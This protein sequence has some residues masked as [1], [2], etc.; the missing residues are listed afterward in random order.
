LDAEIISVEDEW[1]SQ[2]TI[3]VKDADE[4]PVSGATVKGMFDDGRA[5]TCLTDSSG[6]CQ[7]TSYKVSDTNQEAMAFTVNEVS[8]PEILLWQYDASANTDAGDDSN[9]TSMVIDR[10]VATIIAVADIDAHIEWDPIY[11]RTSAT[12]I[13]QD[14]NGLPVENAEV[15]GNW[16]QTGDSFCTTDVNGQCVFYSDNYSASKK[17]ADFE[18]KDITH[19]A[20]F[21]WEYVKDAN[22]D[23]DGDS[24]GTK[25]RAYR[26]DP[27]KMNLVDIDSETLS[28]S[29]E[30]WTQVTFTMRDEQ[31]NPM[32]ERGELFGTWSYDPSRVV[33]CD[34]DANGQ[35][36]LLS[37]KFAEGEVDVISFTVTMVEHPKPMIW[38]Y[39]A[40]Q[41]TDADGDSDGTTITIAEPTPVA[42]FVADLDAQGIQVS[43]SEWKAEVTLTVLD[44]NQ[45][46]V[47]DADVFFLWNNEDDDACT[48]DENGQCTV[49]SDK[50][51]FTQV[52]T[53]SFTITNVEHEQAFVWGYDGAL[54]A[55]V[56]GDSDG[57]SISIGQPQ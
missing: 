50:F 12:V 21:L 10:P 45:N 1:W 52:E 38:E 31:G 37:T 17:D 54:N 44:I 34:L 30:W 39:D 6:M 48:T 3:L 36:S 15:K 18:V 42:M 23:A 25:L 49:L 20:I 16:E 19:S 55:D 14:E 9:G 41:N 5:L 8:H 33:S 11:W 2:V 43:G 35:C 4:L 57:T 28:V 22:T 56:D 27:L 26:P 32:E 51:K 40:A 47:E 53:I 7:V 24:D 13:V 29:D 46:P